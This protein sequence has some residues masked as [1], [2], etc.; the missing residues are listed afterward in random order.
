MCKRYLHL[1]I[2][3]LSAFIMQLTLPGPHMG[4]S[5]VPADM[6]VIFILRFW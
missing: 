5:L 6:V 3:L 1:R 4:T 2:V